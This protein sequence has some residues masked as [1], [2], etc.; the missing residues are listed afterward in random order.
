MGHDDA[1]RVRYRFDEIAVART[2]S[3]LETLTAGIRSGFFVPKPQRPHWPSVEW[4]SRCDVSAFCALRRTRTW[5]AARKR[6]E[7][8][9]RAVVELIDPEGSAE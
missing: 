8:D 6:P 1:E 3:V 5:D 7:D 4:C 2:R 9:I